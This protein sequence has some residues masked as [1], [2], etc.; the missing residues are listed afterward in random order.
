MFWLCY[1][2]S[3][4]S[5]ALSGDSFNVR[6]NTAT[7]K[8]CNH[9]L[10]QLR[11][12]ELQ[13]M[14]DVALTGKCWTEGRLQR[15]FREIQIHGPIQFARDITSLHV[16][17]EYQKNLK[18]LA[19]LQMFCR[20]NGCELIF[21]DPVTANQKFKEKLEWDKVPRYNNQV[22]IIDMWQCMRDTWKENMHKQFDW[23]P[24]HSEATQWNSTWSDSCRRLISVRRG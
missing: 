22:S 8:H 11:P 14:I 6:G 10:N 15:S 12:E 7:L 19:N 3:V 17:R 1:E 2:I 24:L 9:L 4:D 16:Q 5:D 20:K 23:L 18:L 13:E 21:F